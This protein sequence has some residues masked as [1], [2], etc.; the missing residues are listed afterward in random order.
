MFLDN[1]GAKEKELEHLRGGDA[2]GKDM[3]SV[4]NKSGREKSCFKVSTTVYCLKS[5]RQAVWVHA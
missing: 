5:R 4:A 1:V 3:D 2:E